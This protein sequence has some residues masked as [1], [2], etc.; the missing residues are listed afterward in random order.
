MDNR[1]VCF[2]LETTGLS[3]WKHQIIQFAGVAIDLATWEEL[4]GLEVKINFDLAKAT[5]EALE[6]N[7]FDQAVWDREAVSQEDA[8]D[9]VSEFLRDHSTLEKTS[10]KKGTKYMVARLMGHNA[11]MFDCPFLTA[12]FKKA[13]QFLPAESYAPMDTLQLARWK[14]LMAGTECPALGNSLVELCEMF[15]IPFKGAHDA[16]NDVRATI[17]LAKLLIADWHQLKATG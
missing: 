16:L 6:V 15:D 5:K 1:V 17:A 7:H 14:L 12:W 9:Q 2:D 8:R 3:P 13:G 10:K 11:A 4:G